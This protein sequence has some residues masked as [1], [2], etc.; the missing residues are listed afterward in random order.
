MT[1]KQRLQ[2]ITEAKGWTLYRLSK[3]SGVAWST[4]RN[5]FQR[6]TMPTTPTLEALC[7]GLGIGMSELF[8]GED[9]AA[10]SDEHRLLIEQWD[11][12]DDESKTIVMS[13]LKKLNKSKTRHT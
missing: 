6:D 5:M 10:I 12:L 13:L 4:V 2:E 11:S 3:E 1:V 7:K 8:Y 9:M